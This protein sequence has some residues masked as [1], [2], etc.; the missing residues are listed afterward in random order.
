MS[1]NAT[2]RI[3]LLSH[4]RWPSCCRLP[5]ALSQAGFEVAVIASANDPINLSTFIAERYVLPQNLRNLN[6]HLSFIAGCCLDSKTDF[7]MACDETSISLLSMLYD[8]IK[9]SDDP[10]KQAIKN[11]IICSKGNPDYYDHAISKHL[12]VELAYE[13]GIRTP[14]QQLCENTNDLHSFAGEYGYPIVLKREH[15]AAGVFVRICENQQEAET[16]YHALS[17]SGEVIA[18][19]YIEGKPAMANAACYD[20][21]MLACAVFIKEECH[22]DFKGPSAVVRT[23]DHPEMFEA[24]KKFTT[25][26]DY[27]G[28]ISL[29]FMLDENNNAYFIECNPRPT[30]VSHLGFV[31]GTDLFMA[32]YTTLSGEDY[33]PKKFEE[34]LIALFPKELARDPQSLHLETAYHDI[35]EDEPELEKFLL[36]TLKPK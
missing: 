33:Q 30:P 7:L 10:D 24:T 18:Q 15:G 17:Q 12:S 31:T 23:I 1:G 19:R 26:V 28:I 13:V 29:D 9:D 20:G 32:L 8:G 34:K 35:P 5:K 36:S 27:S 4:D 3:I 16:E 14:E 11:L 6:E 22:P 2:K 25:H 21:K